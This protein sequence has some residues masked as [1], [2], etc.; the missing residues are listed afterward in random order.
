MTDQTIAQRIST[1]AD[2][3]VFED[4][5]ADVVERSK[6]FMLDCVGI[7]YAS[8]A[9]DFAPKALAALSSLGGGD[10]PVIGY[11]QRLNLRDATMLNGI[12]VHGL[13]YDDTHTGAV[14][15]AS[16]SAFPTALGAAAANGLTGKDLL[17]GYVMAIEVSTRI[18]L[19]AN[20]EFHNIGFHPTGLTGAFGSAVAAARLFGCNAEGIT[21]AQGIAGST[22]GGIMEFLDDGSW[23]KRAHP[24]HAAATAM[25]SAA[26]ARQGWQAPAAVYEGRFGVFNTHIQSGNFDL[27]ACTKGL[28]EEWEVLNNAIKP[29]PACH[30]THAFA[31]AALELVKEHDLHPADIESMNC[32]IHPTPAGIVC[33]PPEN[34]LVPKSDYDAKFSLP[35]VVAATVSRRGFGLGEL[36]PEALAD[37]EILDLAAK[38]GY[39]DDPESG[40]PKHFSGELIIN[41]TDGRELRHREQ[42]NRGA[43]QRPLSGDEISMKFHENMATVTTRATADRVE[44]LVLGMDGNSSA[45]ELAEGLAT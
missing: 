23:T 21:M 26:F 43:D 25:S 45:T 38:V 11:N 24:G 32:L 40:F 30:F 27:A 20:G 5:P 16:A 42:V 15:H 44:A 3:L 10:H 41:T 19:A 6:Y 33:E 1:F 4:L 36:Q 17:L 28:G 9:F 34:K 29:Y 22:A 39:A 7:A 2:Q 37:R 12:L 14:C 35:F 13:D 8:T 18:G 31:D